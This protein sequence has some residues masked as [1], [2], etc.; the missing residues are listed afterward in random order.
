MLIIKKIYLWF[1]VVLIGDSVHAM[2][3]NLA[4]GACLAIE[5]ALDLA[6]FLYK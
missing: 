5:D 1:K 3:P 6:G 2:A 4:Q